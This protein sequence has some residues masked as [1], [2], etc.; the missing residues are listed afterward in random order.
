MAMHLTTPLVTKRLVLRELSPEDVSKQYVAW[1]NDP[2]INRF[3]ESR[4]STQSRESICQFVDS[5]AA[6]E[7][8]ILFGIF[9][10]EDERHI[11]NIRLG[12]IDPPHRRG[13][14]GLLIGDKLQWGK[15][16]AAEAIDAVAGYALGALDLHKVFAGY[17]AG[18]LGSRKAFRKAGFHEEGRLRDHWFCDGAWQDGCFVCRIRE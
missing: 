6:S 11:G 15:G 1:L 9:L 14:I 3:L 18:N 2:Q 7:T 13:A 12:P 8:D 4:F 10:A 17:Y 16:Y 5:M